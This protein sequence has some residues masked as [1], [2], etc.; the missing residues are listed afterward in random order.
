M[1]NKLKDNSEWEHIGEDR[2]D[3]KGNLKLKYSVYEN[4]LL[5]LNQNLSLKL[6]QNNHLRLDD[7]GDPIGIIESKRTSK[8]PILGQKQTKKLRVYRS[9]FQDYN[10]ELCL[11]KNI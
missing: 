8:D 3:N 9:R 11:K 4:N 6:I 10:N 7:L 1:K 2:Y 5:I